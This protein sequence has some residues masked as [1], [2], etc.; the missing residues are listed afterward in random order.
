MLG[1]S[2]RHDQKHAISLFRLRREI[3]EAKFLDLA[4]ARGKPRG[5]RWKHV[6]WKE[7]LQFAQDRKTNLLTAFA[8][9]EIYFEAIEGEDME[10]VAAVSDIREASALFHY[11]DGAWGTG[12]KALFN[13]DPESAMTHLEDQFLRIS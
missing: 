7:G 3:L 1:W 13:M 8:A 2:P 11:K 6:E 10:D 9:V 5:L 4:S 12:G